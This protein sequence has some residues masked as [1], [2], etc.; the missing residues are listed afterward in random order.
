MSHGAE[1]AALA[2]AAARRQAREA[3]LLKR[4]LQLRDEGLTTAEIA[5]RLG[6]PKAY[7]RRVTLHTK[8]QP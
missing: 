3:A 1:A 7:V 8:E 6:V 5:E 2:D 4:T